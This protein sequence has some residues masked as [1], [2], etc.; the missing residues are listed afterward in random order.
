[1]SATCRESCY[2]LVWGVKNGQ[3]PI[4]E[5]VNIILCDVIRKIITK[6]GGSLLGLN[7]Y[8]D[9]CHCLCVIPREIKVSDFVGLI[10]N[11]SSNK[12]NLIIGEEYIEWQDGFG[13]LTLGKNDISFVQKYI[14]NQEKY[15][16]DN[17]LINVLES[18]PRNGSEIMSMAD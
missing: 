6:S 4:D 7:S 16:R 15:H 11:H 3:G 8:L 5:I 1:M 13:M 18:R 10:K 12:I 17:N 2:H 14:K 9:H